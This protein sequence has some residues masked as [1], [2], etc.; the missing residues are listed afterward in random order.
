MKHKR[1]PILFIAI[2]ALM[3]FSSPALAAQTANQE[4]EDITDEVSDVRELEV[5]QPVEVTPLTSDELAEELQDT[6]L[7]DY[8]PAERYADERELEAFGLLDEDID[9]GELYIA[10]YS[11]QVAGYYDTETSEMVVVREAVEESG[12]TAMEEVTYAH[13]IVHALQD[14]HFDLDAG[15]LNREDVSDDKALAITALIE[16]DAS[17]SEVEYLFERPELL[18][19]FL[20]DIETL[21]FETEV[22]DSAPEIISATLLFPYESGFSFVEAVFAEG[23]WDAVDAMFQDPPASTEQILHPEKYLEGEEPIAVEVAD[24]TSAL[25]GDWTV[26]DENTFGEFQIRTIL[27]QTSMS[28]E[29]AIRAS[30]GWGG[31]TYVVAGTETED[32]IHWELV[33][34]T[35]TDADEFAR[36]WALYEAERWGVDPQYLSDNVMQFESEEAVTRIIL[37]G[38]QVTYL[39]APDIETLEV[40]A[41]SET[42]TPVASP[43]ATPVS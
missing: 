30:E 21:E 28:Q 22:L 36:A 5:L 26:F 12:F 4:F 19:A 17:Y 6:L 16:G 14:Q 23:G 43:V 9:L 18:E 27:E 7:E 25:E 33:W 31:D 2:L 34:D 40:I 29:Q 35:N 8:P 24:F 39:M 38:D 15:V 13:E 11:E 41:A 10:L 20:A 1:Q 37:E 3:L 42:A 32:A